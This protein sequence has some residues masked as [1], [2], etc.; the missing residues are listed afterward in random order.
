MAVR[1]DR[2]LSDWDIFL[3]NTRGRVSIRG[4]LI[5]T[6]M[7]TDLINM[8]ECNERFIAVLWPIVFT[9]PYLA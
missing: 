3:E 5:P 2:G 6:E 9:K 4:N 7:T 8:E 1:K